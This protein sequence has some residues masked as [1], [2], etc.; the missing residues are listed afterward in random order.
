MDA[1]EAS[2]IGA[3]ARMIR[4]RRG[5]SLEVVAG[6]AGIGKQYLSMLELGQRGF[7]R[8]GLLEDLA[9][10]LGCSVVD[11]TGR[12]YLA[13]DR[14]SA[15]TA[16]A[17]PGLSA[18]LHDT[19][20]DD[21]PDI[22]ARPL[23]EL[24]RAA[25]QA[26]AYADDARYSLAGQDLADVITELQVHATTAGPEDRQKALIALA[27]ACMVAYCLAYR[28]GHADL[29]VL[30]ARRGFDAARLAERADLVGMLAMSRTV[31]LMGLG[32]R[33]RAAGLCAEVLN[34]I[35]ALPGPTREDTTVAEAC[36]ILHL[37]SALVAGRDGRTG[38]VATHLAEAR[39]L[40]TH[41]GE[42]NYLRYHFGPT[43]VA[44]WELSIALENGDGPDAAERFAAAP[45][46]L[47][48]L[49]SKCREGYVRF[50]LARCWGQAEGARDGE[51]L[52]ALDAAD[53]LAPV[54]VR[55][56]PIARDLVL[57]LDRRARRRVW[58]LDS[59]RNRF[60]IGGH[61]PRSVDS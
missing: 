28:I 26:N 1:E 10:A 39:S 6:L 42:R 22:P 37:T 14:Q 36:G 29:A 16:A 34:E 46:D 4:R 15:D 25:A 12:P 59:L 54:V 13:P 38:D 19:T 9:T 5:L 60:G 8:R 31:A 23:S 21:V 58:E 43:N 17:M 55:N 30:A 33:R 35:S 50:A 7:N 51:A 48:V 52:R 49:G 32:A 20:L 56:D 61:G 27:E 45:V 44:G 41:T 2:T 53:R 47:S 3:R 11:L 57:S 40:A 24:V 18:A